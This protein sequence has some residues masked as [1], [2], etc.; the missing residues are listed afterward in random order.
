MVITSTLSACFAGLSALYQ[1]LIKYAKQN[2]RHLGRSLVRLM[3]YISFPKSM[4]ASCFKSPINLPTLLT[5]VVSGNCKK[6]CIS[7]TCAIYL[8]HTNIC[9][10]RHRTHKAIFY[11]YGN[12]CKGKWPRLIRKCL[13]RFKSTVSN[14][15][16]FTQM[17]NFDTC[18]SIT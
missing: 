11:T 12:D 10:H 13:S 16:K 18:S 15:H 2:G 4:M 17:G 8:H 6:S 14:L 7:R 3:P 9:N 5:I 1:L